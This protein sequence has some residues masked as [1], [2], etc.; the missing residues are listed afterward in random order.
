[1]FEEK[2]CCYGHILFE[3]YVVSS[4]LGSAFDWISFLF[5]F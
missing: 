1:M 5:L 4:Y 2:V 3:L